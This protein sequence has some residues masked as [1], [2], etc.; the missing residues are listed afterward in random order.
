MRLHLLAGNLLGH[1]EWSLDNRL[2]ILGGEV[3]HLCGER[4]ADGT[5]V[6]PRCESGRVFLNLLSGA[7]TAL[8]DVEHPGGIRLRY[9]RL[10]NGLD[11]ERQDRQICRS[12]VGA[13]AMV[14][15]GDTRRDARPLALAQMPTD[16]VRRDD[17]RQWI[18]AVEL[19]DGIRHPEVAGA[20][21]AVAAVKD[22]VAEHHDRLAHA[23]AAHVLSEGVQLRPLHHREQVRVLVEANGKLRADAHCNGVHLA[24]APLVQFEPATSATWAS[25]WVRALPAQGIGEAS[26]SDSAV[27]VGRGMAIIFGS[28]RQATLAA[29]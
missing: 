24:F 22:R 19:A 4:D 15:I 26:A 1:V 20:H 21:V 9:R 16:K 10:R 3:R 27:S 5:R 23:V 25:L 2:N 29:A 12:V 28:L 8:R 11:R 14:H 13:L 17:E 6:D 7:N 18:V